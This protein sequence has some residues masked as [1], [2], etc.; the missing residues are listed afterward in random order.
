MAD[1]YTQFSFQLENL[2]KPQIKWLGK[3]LNMEYTEELQET[4]ESKEDID[5]WPN[6]DHTLSGMDKTLWI[7]SE[8]EGDCYQ[9][10][11]LVYAFLKKFRPKEVF[12]F[13]AAFTCSKLRL[14]EFGGITYVISKDGIHDTNIAGLIEGALRDGGK[15]RTRMNNLIITVEK[16]K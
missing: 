4:L 8:G 11:L 7:S 1:S 9:A 5:M 3:L 2:T 12:S 10:A 6:F 16:A 14:D 13:S 15:A